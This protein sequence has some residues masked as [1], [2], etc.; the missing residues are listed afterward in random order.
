M[1]EAMLPQPKRGCEECEGS[2]WTPYYREALNG[3]FERAFELCV[4]GRDSLFEAAS[5]LL[6]AC[7]WAYGWF[8]Y[9]ED[10]APDGRV[11]GGEEKA[12]RQLCQAIC[13]AKSVL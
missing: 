1:A 7:E 6:A 12:K 9:F 13:K 8:R 2:G 3:D 11:F 10:H 5:D 4:C